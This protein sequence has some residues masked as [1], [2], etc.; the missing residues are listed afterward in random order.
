MKVNPKIRV[1]RF[2]SNFGRKIT[3]AT[4]DRPDSSSVHNSTSKLKMEQYNKG[5]N[6][7]YDEN[8]QV[9]NDPEVFVAGPSFVDWK[10]TDTAQNE[11]LNE[12]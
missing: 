7:L 6:P 5:K 12:N 10:R 2:T 8:K 9:E 11:N 4:Q 1:S 3:T